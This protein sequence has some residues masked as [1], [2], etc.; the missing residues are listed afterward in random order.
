MGKE[1]T[2]SYA[3]NRIAELEK[4]LNKLKE[5]NGYI[6]FSD[7][8]DKNGKVIHKQI[9]KTYK[10]GFNEL[11]EE[12][13]Q[14]KQQL[15]E[16]DKEIKRLCNDCDKL[17]L[18]REQI[19][20]DATKLKINQ[21]QYDQQI[22][23]LM[24]DLKTLLVFGSKLISQDDRLFMVSDYYMLLNIYNNYLKIFGLSNIDTFND[25]LIDLKKKY[26]E[27]NTLKHV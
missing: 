11:F 24:K 21:K 22:K 5:E 14:L 20:I 10:Q 25:V 16:K 9:Y 7:G 15:E 19:D 13:K 17:W 6:V 23:N 1:F 4:E 12:K 27:F 8:Y 18:S 26:E 3:I 2:K